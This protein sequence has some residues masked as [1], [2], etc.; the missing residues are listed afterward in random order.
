MKQEGS[1]PACV[2]GSWGLW[3]R[4]FRVPVPPNQAEAKEAILPLFRVAWAHK[5][6]HEGPVLRPRPSEV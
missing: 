1:L 5:C 6:Q 4:L 3:L 2:L